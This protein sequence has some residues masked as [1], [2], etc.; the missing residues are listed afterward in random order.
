MLKKNSDQLKK[1]KYSKNHLCEILRLTKYSVWI[2]TYGAAVLKYAWERYIPG[3]GE[4]PPPA[5][6]SLPPAFVWRVS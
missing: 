5:K 2:N 4:L 1:Q 6:S 3:T